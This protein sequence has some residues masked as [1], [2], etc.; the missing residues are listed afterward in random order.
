MDPKVYLLIGIMT[1]I[2]IVVFCGL[3]VCLYI[4]LS[5]KKLRTKSSK[6]KIIK[7]SRTSATD[8]RKDIDMPLVH[9]FVSSK[10]SKHSSKHISKQ[11]QSTNSQSTNSGSKLNDSYSKSA[12]SK[13]DSKL[14]K[15]PSTTNEFSLKSSFAEDTVKTI[16]SEQLKD[17]KARQNSSTIKAAK[18][19]SKNDDVVKASPDLIFNVKMQSELET[20]IKSKIK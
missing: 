15:G 6:S 1:G 4:R 3:M 5:R 12:I 8:E 10:S 20:K 17:Q 18:H 11:S 2:F 9:S 14:E 7:I 13:E 16:N 19:I